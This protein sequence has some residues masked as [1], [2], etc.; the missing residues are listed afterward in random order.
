MPR[1]N[2]RQSARLRFENRHRR[3]LAIA[4]TRADRVLQT[5]PCS[6][7]FLSYGIVCLATEEGDHT[8]EVE[9]P[10]HVLANGAERALSDHP[11]ADCRDLPACL[12]ER[13]KGQMR[14]FL[15][16]E[17]ARRQKRRWIPASLGRLK[18]IA[19]PPADIDM[20]LLTARA[21]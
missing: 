2:D 21:R 5:P 9:R 17:A 12:R 6:S 20:Q 4:V 1:G 19:V 15:F 14:P 13:K 11:Q 16:D 8:I 3:P 7:H 10:R 18:H